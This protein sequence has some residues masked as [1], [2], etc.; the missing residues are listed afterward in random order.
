MSEW[1]EK[2]RGMYYERRVHDLTCTGPVT[3]TSSGEP[4]YPW[5]LPPEGPSDER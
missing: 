5:Q 2:C 4:L 3:Y 1:C